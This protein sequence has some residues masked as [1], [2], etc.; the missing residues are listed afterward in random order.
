M[1]EKRCSHVTAHGENFTGVEH[2]VM[3]KFFMIEKQF[4]QLVASKTQAQTI[5]LR[6]VIRTCVVFATKG[7]SDHRVVTVYQLVLEPFRNLRCQY[8]L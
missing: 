2:T 5:R 4:Q 8:S 1:N 3:L 6:E 7:K